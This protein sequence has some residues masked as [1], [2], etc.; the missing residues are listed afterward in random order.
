MNTTVNMRDVA[1]RLLTPNDTL[2]VRIFDV[3]GHI[4]PDLRNVLLKKAFYI[5][6]R[7]FDKINGVE[8]HDIYINGSSASYFYR[9]KSDIDMRLEVHDVGCPFVSH[10]KYKFDKFVKTLF[11][12]SFL[13]CKFHAENR[14][15]DVKITSS[16]FEIMGLYSILHDKWVIEP[17][18]DI[19]KD[20]DIDD[21]MEEYTR[22][23]YQIKDYMRQMLDTGRN[24]TMEGIEEIKKFY[25]DSI[26][27]NNVS[28]REYVLYK[29]LNYRGIH[30][31][32]KELFNDSLRDYLSL[33]NDNSKTTPL[34]QTPNNAVNS[35]PIVDYNAEINVS[36]T[37]PPLYKIKA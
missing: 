27:N 8:L 16:S 3:H 18:K 32:L 20:L 15:L 36:Y 26:N 28:I 10:D 7:T 13:G 21:I 4:H 1:S 2:D 19:V 23:F 9:D 24:K 12:A 25:E 30:A 34:T 14:F 37:L 33:P 31:Q 29:L 6:N 17:R 35:S 5:F 22:R 11:I